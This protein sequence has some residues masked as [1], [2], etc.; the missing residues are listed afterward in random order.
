MADFSI[1]S[2]DELNILISTTPINSRI[3]GNGHHP[4]EYKWLKDDGFCLRMLKHYAMFCLSPNAKIRPTW[5]IYSNRKNGAQYLSKNTNP[6][7]AIL[8]C[9]LQIHEAEQ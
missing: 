4:F 6:N 2:D 1:F 3:R 7:R 9:F 8:E 5:V